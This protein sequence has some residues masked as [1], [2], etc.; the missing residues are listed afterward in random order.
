MP[1]VLHSLESHAKEMAD[2]LESLVRHFDFCV[3][4]I[5]HTEGGGAAAQNIAGDIPAGVEI[6]RDD[7]GSPAE[8]LSDE[9]Q[10]EMLQVLEKDAAELE[11]VVMEIRDRLPEM[12]SQSEHAAAHLNRLAD[13]YANTSA[14]FNLLEGVGARVPGYMTSS[15]DFRARWDEEKQRIQEQ[16]GELESLREFYEGFLLAYDGLIVE[17][18]RRR[19][20]QNKMESVIK[21]AMTRVEQLYRGEWIVVLP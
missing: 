14:A 10:R 12:E 5:K 6:N 15:R 19:S 7:D 20:V 11:E 8:P 18:G 2:G 16:M 17:V 1:S 4:A 3:T 9:D 21:E 13:I